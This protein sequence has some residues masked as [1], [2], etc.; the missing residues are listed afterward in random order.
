MT[1]LKLE[2]ERVVFARPRRDEAKSAV[3]K[4]VKSQNWNNLFVVIF[5]GQNTE[6]KCCYSDRVTVILCERVY[7]RDFPRIVSP[8]D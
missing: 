5:T 6:G 8:S 2:V 3:V 4:D 1:S 7:S